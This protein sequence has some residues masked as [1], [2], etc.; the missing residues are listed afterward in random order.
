M[1]RITLTILLA[2]A[3]MLAQAQ[4]FKWVD[5]GGRTQYSDR[6]PAPG[7]KFE[8]IGT[9]PAPATDAAP[10]AID[11]SHSLATEEMEFRKR[12]QEAEEKRKAEEQKQKEAQ[13][14]QQNCDAAQARLKTME[15]GGR[16]IKP[17]AEG[18]REYMGDDEIEAESVKAQKDVDEA[19][20]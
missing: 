18:D 12:Q 8:K 3:P 20:K 5:D 7:V 16:I 19:C 6:P 4:L 11:P 15:I 2:L 9:N 14:K 13:S 10:A 17:N 1:L